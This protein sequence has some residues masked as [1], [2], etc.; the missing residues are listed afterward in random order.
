MR[1]SMTYEEALLCLEEATA[2]RDKLP[3]GTDRDLI[4]LVE[5]QVKQFESLVKAFKLRSDK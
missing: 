1:Q 3:P 2:H 4:Y 5:A